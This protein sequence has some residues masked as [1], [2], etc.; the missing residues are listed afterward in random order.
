MS[1]QAHPTATGG[2]PI[3]LW[4]PNQLSHVLKSM[5][6][7]GERIDVSKLTKENKVLAGKMKTNAE[8]QKRIL[9]REV[10]GLQTKYKDQDK[11]A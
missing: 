5:I 6:S 3:T 11:F 7:V 4:L 8:A 10:A 2:T 1:S 9:E